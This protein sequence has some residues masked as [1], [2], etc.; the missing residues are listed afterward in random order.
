MLLRVHARFLLPFGFLL[1][2]KT[3]F[4]CETHKAV[5]KAASVCDVKDM[6][7]AMPVSSQLKCC[8]KFELFLFTYSTFL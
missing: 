3:T 5:R 1:Y 7:Q 2:I 4:L 8:I 6:T